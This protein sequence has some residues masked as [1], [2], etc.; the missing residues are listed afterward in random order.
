MTHTNVWCM[1]TFIHVQRLIYLYTPSPSQLTVATPHQVHSHFVFSV[2]RFVDCH[3]AAV[4][5][6]RR[7]KIFKTRS[8]QKTHLGKCVFRGRVGPVT[9]PLPQLK[10]YNASNRSR[11]VAPAQLHT[12]SWR[13][14]EPEHTAITNPTLNFSEW[15][16]HSQV[17]SFTVSIV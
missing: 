2:A 15:W 6:R 12:Q 1:C 3:A 9:P 10:Q 11:G 16:I 8:H 14:K 4:P 17:A 7:I 13:T 5:S